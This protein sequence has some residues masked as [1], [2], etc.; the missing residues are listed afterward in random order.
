[1]SPIK[2]SSQIDRKHQ[3]FD[4]ILPDINVL[5]IL[6]VGCV[7]DTFCMV[8]DKPQNGFR[9]KKDVDANYSAGNDLSNATAK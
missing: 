7:P 4:G 3:Y 6:Y 1:M 5:Q 8:A 9:K 2:P